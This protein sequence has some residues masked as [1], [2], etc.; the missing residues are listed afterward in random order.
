ML[1]EGSVSALIAQALRLMVN[2]SSLLNIHHDID[3]EEKYTRL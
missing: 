3:R 1:C 2:L